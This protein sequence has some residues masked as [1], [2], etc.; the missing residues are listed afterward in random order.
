MI[1][2]FGVIVGNG[3]NRVIAARYRDSSRRKGV[4]KLMAM[5]RWSGDSKRP[6]ISISKR[7]SSMLATVERA[8]RDAVEEEIA[9]GT[10]G[11]GAKPCVLEGGEVLPQRYNEADH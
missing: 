4:M 6:I 7:R 1:T 8:T 9:V 5:A 3:R 11:R 2:G 10:A